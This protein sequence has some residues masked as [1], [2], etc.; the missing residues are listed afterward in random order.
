MNAAK[1]NSSC[2]PESPEAPLKSAMY[3]PIKFRAPVICQFRQRNSGLS[4]PQQ[5]AQL[6]EDY[7]WIGMK[8]DLQQHPDFCANC[9]QLKV[10]K[11]NKS[12]PN[13]VVHL[14]IQGPFTTY[15]DQKFAA[16]LTDEAT[17]IMSF[18][19]MVGKS[20]ED[21][22]AACFTEWICKLSVPQVIDTNLSEDQAKAL[23]DELDTCL[24]QDI[25]HNPY[26]D[27]NRGSCFNQKAADK[28]NKMVNPAELSW[29]D[30]L[31]ALNFAHNMSYQSAIASTLFETL[32]GYKPKILM[33]NLEAI[34][35]PSTFSTERML[36][37]K[38][39][40]EL[41]KSDVKQM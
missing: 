2:K 13:A 14:E 19:A 33:T 34:S 18:V 6:Q 25:P 5:V 7:C 4:V 17:K 40:I 35:S 27:A 21:L 9:A 1:L 8:K 23:K 37:F 30:S 36:I 41:T 22:A 28:I 26:I 3:L 31:P 20:T 38:K 32:Y 12:V 29:E 24:N 16:V 11:Q 15:G 10:H 39:A